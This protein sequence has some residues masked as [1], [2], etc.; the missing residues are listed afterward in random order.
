M[1]ASNPATTFVR[2]PACPG[3]PVVDPACWVGSTLVARDDWVRVLASNEIAD[4][5]AMALAVRARI[6]DDVAQL[7]GMEP[8]EFELGAFSGVLDDVRAELT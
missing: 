4:L 5:G 7:V 3:M 6:G 8:G 1:T 2:P